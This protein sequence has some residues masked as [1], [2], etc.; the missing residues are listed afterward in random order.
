MSRFSNSLTEYSPRL[1]TLAALASGESQFESFEAIFSEMEEMEL[2]SELLAVRNEEELDLFLGDL[3]K[4][5]G[6]VIGKVVK[7]P[8]GSAIGGVLKTFAG[9]ALPIAGGALGGIIGGPLGAQIGS[10]LASMAGKTLGLELEGLSPE[11]R[12]FESARQFLR[13]ASAAI[14][15]ALE[16]A[17]GVAPPIAVYRAV[18]HAA[19]LHAPG[20]LDD[21]MPLPRQSGR[22]TRRRDH[23]VLFGV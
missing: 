16:S 9:K 13:F 14:R 22:W 12:E 19:G 8:I 20:F 7:S 4:S 11:D 23:I 3:I 21:M 17:P 18:T 5:V 6:S 1:E 15:H 10:G 2:A